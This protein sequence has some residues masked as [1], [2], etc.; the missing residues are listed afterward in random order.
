MTTPETAALLRFGDKLTTGLRA[1]VSVDAQ[2]LAAHQV[3]MTVV[4]EAYRLG[5]A[6]ERDSRQRKLPGV[7]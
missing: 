5:R 3:C 4:A 7:R 6:D 2:R 1:V